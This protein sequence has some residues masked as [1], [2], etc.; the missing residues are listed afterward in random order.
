MGLTTVEDAARSI[1]LEQFEEVAK[2]NGFKKIC[3]KTL[4]SVLDDDNLCVSKEERVL[5]VLVAWMKGQGGV[6]HGCELLRT[7]RFGLMDEEYLRVDACGLFDEEHA[8]CIEPF[9]TEALLRHKPGPAR[10][11]ATAHGRARVSQTATSVSSA[12]EGLVTEFR[13]R[14]I[15]D[16]SGRWHRDST[17]EVQPC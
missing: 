8:K 6:L 3:E 13:V 15:S 7:I 4:N 12:S 1:L 9:V 10:G 11:S 2:T 5:E 17:C 16:F 14:A